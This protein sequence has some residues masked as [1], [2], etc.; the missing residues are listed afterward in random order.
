MEIG[1][2]NL[3][4]CVGKNSFTIQSFLEIDPE[5]YLCF[6]YKVLLMNQWWLESSPT[7][8]WIVGKDTWNASS[9]CDNPQKQLQR[10]MHNVIAPSILDWQFPVIRCWH[11]FKN[12]ICQVTD[13]LGVLSSD[14]SSDWL[15]VLAL[16]LMTGQVTDC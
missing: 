12:F 2:M 15:K 10:W 11:V 4:A 5:T 7:C 13:I 8:C 1:M 3:W 16:W 9:V 6:K 14:M